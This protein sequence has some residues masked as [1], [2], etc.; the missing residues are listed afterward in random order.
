MGDGPCPPTAI[1][2]DQ[3]MD[4]LTGKKQPR[5][6]VKRV[7]IR[8]EDLKKVETVF[9]KPTVSEVSKEKGH[10]MR[11]D[12]LEELAQSKKFMQCLG[13]QQYELRTEPKY[14]RH[15]YQP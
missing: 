10:R 3:N 11:L 12:G 6:R 8:Q 5:A 14:K 4:A 7:K 2:V 9:G 1:V 13:R 15:F